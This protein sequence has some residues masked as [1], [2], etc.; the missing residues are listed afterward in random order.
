M[1]ESLSQ[2]EK[3]EL[4]GVAKAFVTDK[5]NWLTEAIGSAVV[6]VKMVE[7]LEKPDKWQIRMRIQ[8]QYREFYRDLQEKRSEWVRGRLDE[9]LSGQATEKPAQIGRPAKFVW[10]VSADGKGATLAEIDRSIGGDG[11]G[12]RFW[13][14][15][16]TA[17][18]RM[19]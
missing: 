11:V 5:E 13:T 9:L 15:Y 18:N 19:R 17:R 2:D 10:K 8:E 16:T 1:W 14:T 12:P 7:M 3:E 6:W 4:K